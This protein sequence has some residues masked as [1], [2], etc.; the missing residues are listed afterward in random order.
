[1]KMATPTEWQEQ[2]EQ[3]GARVGI[4]HVDVLLDQT[5]WDNCAIP[6]MKMLR[7]DVP[8][9]SL[10]SGTQEEKLLEQAPLL[11][12]LDLA[13]WKHTAWFEELITQ[14]ATDA[15][16]LVLIS[17]LSFDALGRA[18]Q[19]LLQIKWGGQAGLLRYYDPRIFP[20]LMNL[21]LTHEQRAEY[22]RLASYWGW[23]DRDE[24]PHWLQGN[25]QMHQ[26][27]IQVGSAMVLSDQQ[28]DLIGCIS[29]AQS[30]LG[31]RNFDHLGTSQE[32]SFAAL[33]ALVVRASK[34]NYF[35]DLTEYVRGEL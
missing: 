2:I 4:Q 17:P 15:R 11:M 33:Y 8:W 32:S 18:L 3:V 21:I 6:A 26:E 29:D 16:L 20:L 23:L 14:C 1:M 35:G 9:F 24:Q 7:P 12:R 34:E 30:L 13:Q 27:D 28:C 5:A 22:L 31:G 19:V 10:F 25:C